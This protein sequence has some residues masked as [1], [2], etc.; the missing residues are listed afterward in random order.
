MAIEKRYG[1]KA[2]NEAIINKVTKILNNTDYP[3]RK[4]IVIESEPESITTIRYNI[5]ELIVLTDT[6]KCSEGE[7]GEIRQKED[8]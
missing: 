7:F 3:T 8:E 5:T 4:T 2:E 1:N 6:T